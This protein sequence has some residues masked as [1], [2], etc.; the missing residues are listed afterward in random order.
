MASE[1]A[2]LRTLFYLF[3]LASLRRQCP[4]IS[5]IDERLARLPVP[6]GLHIAVAS[7]RDAGFA[8]EWAKPTGIGK[9]TALR[10]RSARSLQQAPVTL[11]LLLAGDVPPNPGPRPTCPRCDRPVLENVAAL[12]CDGCDSWHH[13]KCELLS[14]KA[15]RRLSSS[16]T[17]WYCGVCALPPLDDDLFAP[18]PSS[19]PADTAPQQPALSPAPVGPSPGS[20]RIAVWFSNVRSVKNKTLD[21]Q[22]LVEADPD[23]VFGLCETWLDPS[24]HD[25][26][27]IDTARH[28]VYRRD[29][30]SY[31][32]GVLIMVPHRLPCRRRR[33]LESED[34]EAVFVE[35]TH[36]KGKMLLCCVYCPPST[37]AASYDLL[38]QSLAHVDVSAYSCVCV[39]GD[40]NAHIDWSDLSAPVPL[41]PHDDA[42]LDVMET[43]GFVQVCGEPSYRSI[44][45]KASFLDLVFVSNLPLITDC[46]IQP[47]LAGSDH[48]AIRFSSLLTLPKS[49]HYSKMVRNFSRMDLPHL[50]SLLHLAPWSLVLDTPSVDEA[51]DMW[52]DIM[53]AIEADCVPSKHLSGRRRTPWISNDIIRLSHKKRKLFRKA[54]KTNRPDVLAAARRAQRDLKKLVYTVHKE[55]LCVVAEKAARSPKLFWAY[56]KSQ[57][58]CASS[59]RHSQCPNI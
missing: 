27:L 33:D 54:K 22:A 41:S 26:Q 10:A 25:G 58:R 23:T 42:L 45:G 40:F 59:S 24:V 20:T 18:A 29:R 35:V 14:I 48:N 21:F 19:Q 55:Y 8:V 38:G 44:T 5:S 30:A 51:Y 46:S 36:R 50:N 4:A 52:L 12:Q 37:R 56:I 16:S 3:V 2:C 47:S 31:G 11:L 1:I 53:S 15:Y 6:L 17:E 34:L 57:R 43:S 39:F 13:R 9:T 7:P 28:V 32:G 49:G